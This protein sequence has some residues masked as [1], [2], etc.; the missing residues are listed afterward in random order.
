MKTLIAKE[1]TDARGFTLTEVLIAIAIFV[2]ALGAMMNIYISG[3]RTWETTRE[4]ADLQAQARL[5]MNTMVT[6][7]RNATRTSTQNP[8]P[9]LT[10]PSAPNNKNINFRLPGDNNGDGFLTDANGDIEWD[11]NN[12]IDY[13]YIPGQMTLRRLEKGMQTILSR[14]VQDVQFIDV[15]IDPTLSIYELR[16]ILALQKTTAR[17][18]NITVTLSSFVRLR[19]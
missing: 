12:P 7:L 13:Q 6:E 1:S 8:S 19:N 9:N 15:T 17:Q 5:A 4:L 14:D 3:I 11:T 16:I 2:L 10:I 18:R